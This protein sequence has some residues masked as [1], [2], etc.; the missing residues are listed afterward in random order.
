M[1]PIFRVRRGV[2]G[3]YAPPPD[4]SITHRALMLAAVAEG[5]SRVRRPLATGDCVSTRRCLESLG[6]AFT[7]DGDGLTVQGVGLRGLREPP[8]ALDAENSG[9]TTRLLSGLIA[10]QALFAVLG[11]DDSLV[12]RPMARVVQPLRQMGAR[13]EGRDGGRFAPLCFLPGTGDLQPLEWEIPVPSAQVKSCLLLAALRASGPSTIRGKVASRDHTERMV[14]SLGVRLEAGDSLL[15][16]HPAARLP[17]FELEVPGD[18]SSAAFFVAASLVSGK[19]LVLRSCGINPTRLGFIE[20]ARRMGA[21]I[22]VEQTGSALGEPC[23]TL[24]VTPGSLRGTEVGPGEV[25]E[26]IDEIPL[27]AVLG[28][29]ARGVTRVSGAAELRVKESDRLEMIA[30]M[31]EGLGG[32]IEMGEDG[33]SME[34]PQQLARS[35]SVDPRGDHRI[36]MAAAVAAAGTGGSVRVTGFDCSRVSYPDFIRDFTALGGEVA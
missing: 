25:P 17:G 8:G 20:A 4:K 35:A 23:G 13:I 31:V 1:D 10:G 2:G 30:R 34:G 7:E 24:T 3:T 22:S 9:T 18:V 14:Q 19:P 6:A 26:L 15:R 36:A 16:V 12:R 32:K 29:F 28:L 27:L 11:G 5:R 33:F 21:S